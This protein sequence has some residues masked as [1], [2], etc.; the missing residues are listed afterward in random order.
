MRNF[1]VYMKVKMMRQC[2]YPQELS[3]PM[4]GTI[5]LG[6]T[7]F[8]TVMGEILLATRGS[9]VKSKAI[10]HECHSRHLIGSSS[11]R[12]LCDCGCRES[13]RDSQ[14]LYKKAAEC[15]EYPQENNLLS[16]NILEIPFGLHTV[17]LLG[18][19]IL[20]HNTMAAREKPFVSSLQS[21][22]DPKTLPLSVE[23]INAPLKAVGRGRIY[24]MFI[25]MDM[26]TVQQGQSSMP[27]MNYTIQET[28]NDQ[29]VRQLLC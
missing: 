2:S 28:G 14:S 10:S 9:P 5:C 11:V 24:D 18:E 13:S 3:S 15:I 1:F 25:V 6:F 16:I 27:P 12:L 21:T 7:G 29:N 26:L 19:I 17:I 20:F 8:I 23:Q 22:T 4:M